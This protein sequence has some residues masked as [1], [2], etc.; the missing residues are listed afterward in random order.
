MRVVWTYVQDVADPAHRGRAGTA[1]LAKEAQRVI[2]LLATLAAAG[3]PE[4]AA[5]QGALDAALQHA[6]PGTTAPAQAPIDTWRALDA[7][8]PALDALEPRQKQLLVEAMVVAAM[9]DN[10]LTVEEAELLRAACMALHLPMPGL[11]A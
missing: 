4:P 1:T 6:L 2:T 10:Q 7:G 5:A 3:N 11:I 9:H 8:W